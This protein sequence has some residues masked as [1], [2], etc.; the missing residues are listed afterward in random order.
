MRMH[1][2]WAFVL[3]CGALALP[4][5]RTAR[6]A[7]PTDTCD[8]TITSL[9]VVTSGPGTWCVTADLSSSLAATSLI[10]VGYPGSV[11]DCLDHLI[12]GSGAGNASTS[13]GI[14]VSE[15]DDIVIRNCHVRGFS[16]GISVEGS[17]IVVE[18]NLV[19]HPL[20]SGIEVIGNAYTIRRNRVAAVGGH[21]TFHTALGINASGSGQIVDNDV[22]GV[23]ATAG[24]AGTNNGIAV[25]GLGGV[26]I[27]GNRVRG[28]GAG[29][30]GSYGIT[31]F[32]DST[33]RVSIRGNDIVG[34]GGIGSQGMSCTG[35]NQRARNNT[36]SGF[37][38]G[39]QACGNS[40]GNVV[41]P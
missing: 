4:L 3:V 18:D 21:A 13:R 27:V 12:D 28:I 24:G 37:T 30:T 23:D 17:R 19:E 26:A 10:T 11:L 22:A 39:I 14:V 38:T 33:Q 36:I 9:P 7:E 29:D 35:S 15:V 6:A 41:R 20:Y 31:A 2:V 5:S 8:H 32:G 40:A 34:E 1:R 16:S 25:T